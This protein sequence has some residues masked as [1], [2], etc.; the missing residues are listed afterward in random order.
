LQVVLSV[1]PACSLGPAVFVGG[2]ALGQVWLFL[3]IPSLAGAAAGWVFR[4][5][6]L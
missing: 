4:R 6:A 1:N 3:V 5:S 2:K